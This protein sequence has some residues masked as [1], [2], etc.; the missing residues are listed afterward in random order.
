MARSK[1]HRIA[2]QL[3]VLAADTV[4]VLQDKL[5]DGTPNPD[6]EKGRALMIKET[7]LAI[8]DVV[9]RARILQKNVLKAVDAETREDFREQLI[10][11]TDGVA[12]LKTKD[13]PALGKALM[14]A[15]ESYEKARGRSK[16]A[17]VRHSKLSLPQKR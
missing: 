5:K 17:S 7:E 16:A 8:A 1:L 9:T 14:G 15:L 3:A 13:V 11:M 4:P 10:L 6:T 12:S 2:K